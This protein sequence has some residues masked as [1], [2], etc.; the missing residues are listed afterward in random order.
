MLIKS[1]RQHSL[2]SR[3]M[4]KKKKQKKT[5]TMMKKRRDEEEL[6]GEVE[7]NR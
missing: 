6:V 2:I 4:L 5:K 3:M 7:G 1:L